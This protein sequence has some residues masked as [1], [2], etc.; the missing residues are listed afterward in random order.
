MDT[1]VPIETKETGASS[2]RQPRT[3]PEALDRAA[4]RFGGDEALVD[5]TTRLSFRDLAERVDHVAARAGGE[6]Y[7]RA[8]VWPCGRRTALHG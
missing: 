1:T 7:E 3:I 6:R 8:T 4:E 5:G 2:H